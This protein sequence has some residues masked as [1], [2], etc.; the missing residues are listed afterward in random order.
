MCCRDVV[1]AA[2]GGDIEP[3][4]AEALEPLWSLHERN[5][6]TEDDRGGRARIARTA[7]ALLDDF[8]RSGAAESLSA[9]CRACS[10]RQKLG[11]KGCQG[12]RIP[13]DK[14]ETAVLHQI[15]SLYRDGALIREALDA[16]T[17]R[18]RAEGPA[19]EEQRRALAEETRRTERA[20]D[21]YYTAFEAGELDAK[22]FQTASRRS[23]RAWPTLGEEDLAFAA[24]LA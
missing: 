14:L 8:T 19:L 11:P 21:R 15:A 6:L 7:D 22:R 3:P 2:V 12:E 20:L 16:A 18:Q 5:W 17:E 24:R 1:V 13:R 10:G 23:R 9:Q 4:L